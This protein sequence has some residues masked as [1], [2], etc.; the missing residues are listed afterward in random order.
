MEILILFFTGDFLECRGKVYFIMQ[1]FE[2]SRRGLTTVFIDIV[3]S[4]IMLKLFFNY[5]WRYV[6]VMNGTSRPSTSFIFRMY[7]LCAV[8][9]QMFSIFL[10]NHKWLSLSKTW[11]T[12][13]LI[14]VTLVIINITLMNCYIFIFKQRVAFWLVRRFFETGVHVNIEKFD[15]ELDISEKLSGWLESLKFY[16]VGFNCFVLLKVPNRCCHCLQLII[17]KI[18]SLALY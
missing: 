13:R 8:L 4:L 16:L 6:L 12:L 2:C 10:R 11:L 1:R 14:I 3:E 5:F 7:N 17:M 9:C 18:A 15:Q